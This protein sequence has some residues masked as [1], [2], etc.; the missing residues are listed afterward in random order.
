MQKVQFFNLPKV[1]LKKKKK[2]LITD[3]ITPWHSR[4]LHCSI[5]YSECTYY[6]ELLSGDEALIVSYEYIHFS[7]AT[8]YMYLKN[9]CKNNFSNH[10][11]VFQFLSS[12]PTCGIRLMTILK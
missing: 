7:K 6:A 1:L 5:I 12:P 9:S 8:I 4:F 2:E 11:Q 10:F 3:T